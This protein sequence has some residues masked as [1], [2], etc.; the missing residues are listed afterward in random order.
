MARKSSLGR[1]QH[2]AYNGCRRPFAPARRGRPQLYCSPACRA[3]A[4][5]ERGTPRQRRLVRLVQAE[6]QLALPELPAASIVLVITDP[7]YAFERGD[8]YFRDWFP[9]LPDE[10]WAPIFAGLYRV[11]ARHGTAYVFCDSRVHPIFDEAARAAGFRIRAPLIWDKLSIG[12]GGGWRAQYELVAWYEKGKPT[13]ASNS[14]GNVRHHAPRLPDREASGA[15]ARAHHPIQLRRRRHPRPVL[16][17]GR[18]RHGGEQAR[19]A[20][21]VDRH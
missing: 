16:R 11:L 13:H 10:A 19:A 21:R 17:V 15:P 3:A 5:R 7:P 20:S 9:M 2:C 14:L 4:H 6:S 1:R 12:L 8:T 18:D